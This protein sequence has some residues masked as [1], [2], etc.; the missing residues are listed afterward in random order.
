MKNNMQI[1]KKL[2]FSEN[3]SKGKPT[4]IKDNVKCNTGVKI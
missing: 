2:L 3:E 1:I 4:L